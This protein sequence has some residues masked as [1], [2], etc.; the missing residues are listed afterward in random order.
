MSLWHERAACLGEPTDLW[1]DD[2][3]AIETA[4]LSYCDVCP[5]QFECRAQ[6]SAYQ[7]TEGI[8]GGLRA[9]VPEERAI[10]H[11]HPPAPIPQHDP[12]SSL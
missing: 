5:V 4:A 8:W 10:L 1:F 12:R 3:P 9:Y 11:A 2:D 7:E 6:A